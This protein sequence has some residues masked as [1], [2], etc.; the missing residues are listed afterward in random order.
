MKKQKTPST[1]SQLP[2]GLN[3]QRYL[4]ENEE[5]PGIEDRLGQPRILQHHFFPDALAWIRQEKNLTDFHYLD[6]GCGHGN[7]LRAIKKELN[8]EGHF[9]GISLSRAE[10]VHG[11]EFY[12]E[13]NQE[14]P[15]ESL[16]MFGIGNLHNLHEIKVFDEK[17]SD[18]S[19]PESL[20]D[21]TFD[22]I[23]MEAVL[24]ASGYGHDTYEKK[25]ESAQQILS[26]LCR[27]CKKDGKLLGRIMAFSPV[28]PKEEQFKLLRSN[29]NWLFVPGLDEVI[30]ML[31]IAGFDYIQ[32]S[33]RPHEKAAMPGKENLV[34]V[35]F[36]AEKR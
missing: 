36:L 15:K 32:R 7:D 17:T 21:E 14:D 11:L 18:F 10:I 12:Q 1:N 6:A 8:G 4:K 24:H 34:K 28:I 33:I 13:R 29:N 2:N 22:L 25:K 31:T 19:A 27:V 3:D 23:F 26:E 35:S 5:W 16:S 30:A 9:L 20:N